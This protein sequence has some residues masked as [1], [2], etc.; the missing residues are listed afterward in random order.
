MQ[1]GHCSLKKSRANRHYLL[2]GLV[3]LACLS[4][5]V[6]VLVSRSPSRES[7]AQRIAAVNAAHAL[8]PEQNAATIYDQLVA[9]LK[10]TGAAP[11]CCW[12]CGATMTRTGA[13]RT[14]WRRSEHSSPS[15]L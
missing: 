11:A 4:I 10:I 8:P 5:G 7:L 9:S 6:I 2:L 3:V 15:R 14:A 12:D 1:S 13:G